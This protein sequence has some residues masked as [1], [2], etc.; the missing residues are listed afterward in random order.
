MLLEGDD[1]DVEAADLEIAQY[2]RPNWA[3]ARLK[4]EAIDL[5]KL[6]TELL[7][8]AGMP[9]KLIFS[10]NETRDGLYRISYGYPSVPE[11]VHDH[12]KVNNEQQRGP[13]KASYTFQNT[14]DA[15]IL[16]PSV[17]GRTRFAGWANFSDLLP[18]TSSD[19]R[20]LELVEATLI[21]EITLRERSVKSAD[22]V[23]QK[24]DMDVP[25][26][27]R[28]L[29]GNR[30]WHVAPNQNTTPCGTRASK[31]AH[32]SARQGYRLIAAF[33]GIRV[34]PRD[35]PVVLRDR[36]LANFRRQQLCKIRPLSYL[37]PS[38][39]AP[40]FVE[41]SEAATVAKHLCRSGEF[42][43]PMN[44][45]ATLRQRRPQ[46]GGATFANHSELLFVLRRWSG[47]RILS[48]KETDTPILHSEVVAPQARAEVGKAWADHVLLPLLESADMGSENT[49]PASK[50]HQL[51]LSTG[52]HYEYTGALPL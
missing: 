6:E 29:S 34:L 30:A 19:E 46:P 37:S 48:H 4:S 42:F 15:A 17:D 12:L 23:D 31:A 38:A 14:I 11:S 16:Q 21:V 24:S 49:K 47:R 44:I 32:Q 26:S 27:E 2:V 35:T 8:N 36:Q 43:P 13:Q 1:Y 50:A 28:I 40:K 20:S 7:R 45:N 22:N 33:E 3:A 41:I 10:G 9:D 52:G 18:P 39:R 51:S 25:R 5:R